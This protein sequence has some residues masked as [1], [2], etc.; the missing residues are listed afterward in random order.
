L[1]QRSLSLYDALAVEVII[2]LDKGSVAGAV[3]TSIANVGVENNRDELQEELPE[4]YSGDFGGINW[5]SSRAFTCV[6]EAFFDVR[7][8]QELC[9]SM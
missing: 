3:A 5:V 4:S 6:Y 7:T 8:W 1:S 2:T 9:F